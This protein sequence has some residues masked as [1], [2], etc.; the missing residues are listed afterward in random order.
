MS[1][2]LLPEEV[3][4]KILEA[5]ELL[6]AMFPLP[7]E[8]TFAD[9]TTP[10]LALLRASTSSADLASSLPDDLRVIILLHLQDD[11]AWPLEVELVLRLRD[12]PASTASSSTTTR[13][14]PPTLTV[15]PPAWLSRSRFAELLSG[16]PPLEGEEVVDDVLMLIEHLRSEGPSFI[17][18][19]TPEP[20]ANN[21]GVIV[22]PDELGID[23]VWFWL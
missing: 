6:E 13:G 22:E 16:L 2:H 12:D 14:L 8:L 5:I 20:V 1:A 17:P 9:S 23:R 10:A 19:L 3:L 21:G 15:R 7:S 18:P 4:I 11:L